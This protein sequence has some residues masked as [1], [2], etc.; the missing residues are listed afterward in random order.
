MACWYL[1]AGT[2]LVLSSLR[3]EGEEIWNEQVKVKKKQHGLSLA[4]KEVCQQYL[5]QN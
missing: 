2:L 1:H 3:K 4:L 5:P